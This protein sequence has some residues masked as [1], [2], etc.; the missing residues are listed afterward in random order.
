MAGLPGAGRAGTLGFF[1]GKKEMGTEGH[2]AV[3]CSE[4]LAVP[5]VPGNQ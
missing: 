2:G 5:L 3:V 1:T 4:Q